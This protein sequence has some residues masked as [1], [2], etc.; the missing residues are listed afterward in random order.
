MRPS[1]AVPGDPE[2]H[3]FAG[4]RQSEQEQDP[5]EG[6]QSFGPGEVTATSP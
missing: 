5:E 1:T 2:H 6:G 4:A 3:R